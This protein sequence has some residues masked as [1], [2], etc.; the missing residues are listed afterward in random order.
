MTKNERQF[1]V[2]LHF[3]FKVHWLLTEMKLKRF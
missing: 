2:F 3:W 1:N